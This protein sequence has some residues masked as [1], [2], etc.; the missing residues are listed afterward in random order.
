METTMSELDASGIMYAG[1]QSHKDDAKLFVTFSLESRLDKRATQEAN[2]GMNKYRDVEFITIRVPGDK[3]LSIHRPV[4]H[5]DK[6]RFPLQY[7]AFKNSVTGDQ[8]IGTPLALWPGCKPSQA[9]E[10]AYFNV[11]TVEQLAAMP[12]GVGGASMMGVQALR[13]AARQF[14]AARKEEAPLLKVQAELKQRDDQIAA[15]T[16]QVAQQTALVN[17][18]IA[19]MGQPA[20]VGGDKK[21]K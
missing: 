13:L 20:P 17:K 18:L 5:S 10:L 7:A 3:T 12:D 8:V 16:D 2:D 6:M 9:Q 21:G 19:N 14:V 1:E 11:R 4:V 15:L